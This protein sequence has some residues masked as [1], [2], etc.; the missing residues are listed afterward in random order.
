MPMPVKCGEKTK[1]FWPAKACRSVIYFSLGVMPKVHWNNLYTY[2]DAVRSLDIPST[3]FH[4]K[5]LPRTAF[6]LL[7][8]VSPISAVYGKHDVRVL[9]LF[10]VLTVNLLPTSSTGCQGSVV[11]RAFETT[12]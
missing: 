3:G 12:M 2:I 6:L 5:V 1:Y 11:V 7:G 4:F 9:A 8:N 10:D